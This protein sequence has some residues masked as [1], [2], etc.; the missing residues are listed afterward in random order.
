MAMLA[1]APL[2][3]LECNPPALL[4]L[5]PGGQQPS[6]PSQSTLQQRRHQPA[7]S[8]AGSQTVQAARQALRQ[9]VGGWPRDLREGQQQEGH[10]TG[11]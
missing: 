11:N 2:S 10:S 4:W 5:R 8:L 3:L 7:T 1:H 6:S 9:G